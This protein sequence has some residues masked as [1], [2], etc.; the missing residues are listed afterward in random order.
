M[1]VLSHDVI[2]FIWSSPIRYF[3]TLFIPRLF[4]FDLLNIEFDHDD[5]YRSAYIPTHF[6]PIDKGR[7]RY[8]LKKMFIIYQDIY[9]V[10]VIYDIACR[11]TVTNCIGPRIGQLFAESDFSIGG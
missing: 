8:F 2:S 5:S 3:I 11:I 9:F 1:D 6:H 10:I 4:C 7:Y